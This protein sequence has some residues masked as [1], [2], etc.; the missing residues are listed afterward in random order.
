MG[1]TTIE[2]S[3]ILITGGAGFIGSNLADALINDNEIVVV[4][5]LS[6]GKK[7]N[8]PQGANLHFIE[9]SIADYEFMSTLL[10]AWKF[11]YIFLLAAVA[12]VADTI[13]RPAETH[14]INQDANLNILETIRIKKLPVKKILFSS[15]AAVY[16][17]NP[18]L[19]KKETSPIDPLSPYAVDKFATERFVIDYGRLYDIPTVATRFF[20]VY[21]PKQNPKSPYSGVLSLVLES[22]INGQTFT[23]FGDGE[24]TRD[25]VHVEDVVRAL[26]VLASHSEALHDV[27]NVGTGVETSL[28]TVIRLFEEIEHKNLTVSLANA[29]VGDIRESYCDNNKLMSMESWPMLSVKDGLINY[30]QYTK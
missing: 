14:I 6:M 15:S 18:E 21:G 27:Y 13:V 17:N 23:V 5:D 30:V 25:F 4:D 7:K 8:L 20:N 29:R 1:E 10:E 16:G 12:S 24:Q 3:K 9:H 2:N 28:N 26:T 19:P 11:D 22:I